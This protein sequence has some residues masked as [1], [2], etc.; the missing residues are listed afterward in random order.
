MKTIVLFSLCLATVQVSAQYS[1]EGLDLDKD[2]STWF[3]KQIGLEKTQIVL[4]EYQP[5]Q[6]Y[7]YSHPFYQEK[8]WM[9][10]SIKYRGEVFNGLKIRYNA[11]EDYVLLLHPTDHSLAGE[12]IRLNNADISWFT[13]DQ[14]LFYHF[15]DLDSKSGI[16]HL[17][18]DGSQLKFAAK[19][20]KV[21]TVAE[22]QSYRSDDSYYLIE[23]SSMVSIKNT[24][25]F[26]RKFPEYKKE[27]KQYGNQI[28][29]KVSKNSEAY[30]A[31]LAEWC[32]NKILGQ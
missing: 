31:S 30:L 20:V 4:G 2:V 27:I 26:V 3:D 25:S 13:L 18:Y 16:Y 8:Y 29:R 32:N 5:F 19:R 21:E 11:F 22:T 1:T 6:F 24:S 7:P 9:D 12:P 23:G 10:G 28:S 15:K 17:L 14:D